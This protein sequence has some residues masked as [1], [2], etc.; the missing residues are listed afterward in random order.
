MWGEAVRV[1]AYLRNRSP[2]TMENTPYE[3]W[4]QKQP[5]LA[6]IKLFGYDAFAKQVG[7]ITKLE[8]RSKK[9]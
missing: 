7:N 5:N 8:N 3:I 1:A 6:N 2:T 9:F 4:E